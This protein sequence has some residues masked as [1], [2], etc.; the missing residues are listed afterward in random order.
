M[1]A[2]MLE[3]ALRRDRRIVVASIFA[4][5]LLAWLF[6]A[7]LSVRMD[8]MDGLAARMMGMPADDGLSRVLAA[9]LSPRAAAAADATVDFCLVALM[10]AVMMV[11]MMLPGAAP[12]I[13]LFSALERKRGAGGIGGRVACFVAGYVA[14]WGLF[15]VVAAALQ[16]G[17]SRVGLLS[18]D[19]VA[20][21][22][23]LAGAMFAAAGIYEFTPL[24]HRCLARCRSPLEW[25]SRH[26]RPG[27]DGA[28]LMGIEHGAYC[29]GCCWVIMLLIF[30]GGVMNLVWVAVIAAFVLA[31]KIVSG[32][33][34][35]TRLVGLALACGGAALMFRALYA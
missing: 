3:I 27:R 20:T 11:A 16:T 18:M 26:M 33:P 22:T 32:S 13:L 19:M 7:H 8:A 30:V 1:L 34:L 25:I 15:S 24:K 10:W 2:D 31:Q 4:I 6:L 14:V 28:L 21:S 12:T 5:C 35:S 9:A 29:V 23:L 17:L